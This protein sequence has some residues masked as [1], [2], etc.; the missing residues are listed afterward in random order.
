MLTLITAALPIYNG[1]HLRLRDLPTVTYWPDCHQIVGRVDHELFLAT[2]AEGDVVL[3]KSPDDAHPSSNHDA[4][5]KN[6]QNLPHIH[7]HA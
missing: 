2:D 6:T 5:R 4:F 7:F 3:V 1:Q